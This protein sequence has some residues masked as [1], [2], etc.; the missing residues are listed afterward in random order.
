M[1]LAI[2]PEM[3]LSELQ[4]AFSQQFPYLNLMFFT[5][6]HEAYKASPAKFMITDQDT[7]L[8]VLENID[9]PEAIYLEPEMPTWQVERLFEE[10]FGLHVQVFRKS[11]ST[12]LATSKSD[13]LSLEQQN[14]KGRAS[15]HVDFLPPDEM[16]YRDKD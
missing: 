13:D 8:S 14:A 10:L 15:E 16:D 7:K 3:Q 12:W 1:K 2:L 11:G 9:A 6:P 4:N 5:K